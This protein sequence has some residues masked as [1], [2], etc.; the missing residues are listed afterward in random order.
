MDLYF[1]AQRPDLCVLLT[2]NCRIPAVKVAVVDWSQ[3]CGRT[4]PQETR[5]MKRV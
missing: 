2:T 3:L 1:S 4:Q 5:G